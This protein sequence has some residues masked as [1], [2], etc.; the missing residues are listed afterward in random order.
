MDLAERI[1]LFIAGV[2][3]AVIVIVAIGAFWR[4]QWLV[5]FTGLLVFLLTFVPAI[6]ER[7][8]RVR[9]P[10]EFTLV[11]SVFLCASFA[12]GE[13]SDF[14]ERFWW[15]DL[16]LHGMS[17]VVT[18]LAGFLMVYVFYMT[19]RVRI[20]PVYVAI[21]SF[22]FAM[23]LGVIWEI[24]EFVVDWTMELDLQKSGLVDTMTDLMINALGALI[25]AIT[26]YRYVKNG[27]SLIAFHLI[28]KFVDRN[29]AL[30][31]ETAGSKK[32]ETK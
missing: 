6:I 26:G 27:D 5:A 24:F 25:A 2:L 31:P 23:T 22:G 12:L 17:A 1:E 29:A 20:A 10:V 14:Y 7:R 15:W 3:Q 21:I 11:T 8:L 32:I 9:L 13:V 16:M 28:Q 19:N 4:E 18:G 30:F